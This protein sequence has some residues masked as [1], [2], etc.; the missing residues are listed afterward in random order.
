MG[1][2]IYSLYPK[3]RTHFQ[4]RNMDLL[5][6]ILLCIVIIQALFFVRYIYARKTKTASDQV[7]VDKFTESKAELKTEDDLTEG[8]SKQVS[9]VVVLKENDA[10]ILVSKILEYMEEHRPYIDSGLELRDLAN[11]LNVHH[12]HIT[13]VLNSILKQN[14]YD[15]INTYRVEEVKKQLKSPTNKSY[16]ILSIAYACGFS[17]KSSFNRVFKQKTGL[18]PF[19][20]RKSDEQEISTS[21]LESIA[22]D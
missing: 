11:A 18:T 10:E 1:L 12:S 6:L 21:N 5:S 7:F 17:A 4:L 20:Y 22:L 16:T 2:H 15:F 19:E 3:D 9:H 8:E 14:F 13:Y